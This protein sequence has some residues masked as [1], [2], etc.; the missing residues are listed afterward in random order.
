MELA[1]EWA[2]ALAASGWMDGGRDGEE[3]GEIDG[4]R[5]WEAQRVKEGWSGLLEL[6]R[7]EMH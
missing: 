2:A 4:G 3:D 6:C 1:F 5:Q 7:R